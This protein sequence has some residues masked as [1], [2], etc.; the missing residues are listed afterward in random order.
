VSDNL[1][2]TKT[3]EKVK[4][5]KKPKKDRSNVLTK[6]FKTE[7]FFE[8]EDQLIIDG[9]SKICNWI[10][11]E[12]LHTC[13]TDYN[14]NENKLKLT[15]GYNTR[16]YFINQIKPNNTF[17][18]SVYGMVGECAALRVKTSFKQFFERGNVGFPK[19][20]SWKE[21]WFS[22]EYTKPRSQGIKI[23][24][25][26]ITFTLGKDLNGKQMYVTGVLKDAVKYEKYSLNT[27]TLVKEGKQY[28]VCFS[29]DL[30]K[31]KEITENQQRWCSI[32]P[33]HKNMFVMLDYKMNTVEFSVIQGIKELDKEIDKVQGKLA[34]C[35][36]QTV[37]KIYK[38]KVYVET[39]ITYESKRYTKLNKTLKKLRRKRQEQIKQMLYTIANFLCKNYDYIMIGDYT[40]TNEVA[41][42]KNQKRS[43]LNQTFIGKF[44]TILKHVATKSYKKC[45]VI[46]EKHTTATCSCCGR[47][48]KK[49]PTVRVFTCPDCKNT[50]GRDIN[51]C[52]NIAKK[53]GIALNLS[54]TDYLTL[55]DV[56]YTISVH[57]RVYAN[58]LK[59]LL[60][61]MNMETTSCGN[62]VG[63]SSLNTIKQV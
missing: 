20:N 61:Y 34:L 26:N 30:P 59:K 60:M 54:G 2:V 53:G 44:R 5:K 49:D 24:D 52:I 19:Y 62:E 18:K 55:K 23:N 47:Y 11:N 31:R 7:V 43:M 4:S 9:Q 21:N 12:V 45:V 33:N 39:K 42:Y 22:L 27:V 14:E 48:E 63:I 46:D 37:K 32:D 56:K 15:S 38:N 35:R 29:C 3:D 28:F 50:I 58:E 1:D 8:K 51:S 6:A 13:I 10:Y 16:D 40:P 36:K 17:T 41:K 25:K 57:R